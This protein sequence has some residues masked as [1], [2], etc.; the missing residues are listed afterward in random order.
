MTIK[1]MC[2]NA[3]LGA[4]TDSS[5]SPSKTYCEKASD[6]FSRNLTTRGNTPWKKAAHI[7]LKDN[8]IQMS[9]LLEQWRVLT[10]NGKYTQYLYVPIKQG[11]YEK[12]DSKGDLVGSGPLEELLQQT[13]NDMDGISPGVFA[14]EGFRLLVQKDLLTDKDLAFLTSEKSGKMFKTHNHPVLKM[15][16]GS[17]DDFVL[18]GKRRYYTSVN[19]RIGLYT[20]FLCREWYANSLVPLRTWF[21][22]KGVDVSEILARCRR[23]KISSGVGE[24][25]EN[26]L[27]IIYYGAPGT[28]KSF[29]IDEVIKQDV[30]TVRTTFHPDSDYS[31]FVGTYK[32]TMAKEGKISYAFV[33]QAFLK[34]YINAWERWPMKIA[35]FLVIE[36]INRGNCAQ[37]FGD[38]FQL[39]DRTESGWSKY[40][41]DGDK[42]LAKYLGG[43]MPTLSSADCPREYSPELWE[44]IKIGEKMALPPNLYIWAT[45]NTS[46][47]SLFPVDSAF[48]RRWDWEYVPI[49][50]YPEKNYQLEIDG[51]VYEWWSFVKAIND[52]IFS[53]TDS[54]DKKLGYFFVKAKNVG[55][56]N[57]IDADKFLNK[58]I[59]YLWNDVF[60]NS[61]PEKAFSFKWSDGEDA[62]LATL[63]DFFK[64]EDGSRDD[65]ML[66][67]F[68]KGLGVGP[69]ATEKRSGSSGSDPA[70]G[71][72]VVADV[73]PEPADDESDP[74]LRS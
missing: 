60:K 64:K 20:Y 39:L 33:G 67:A 58:V 43:E 26:R 44:K 70:Y 40:P 31:S 29:H 3:G 30:E 53:A 48:K 14:K 61:E 18:H 12:Y 50:N 69:I 51:E 38:V 74:A 4:V 1:E 7:I 71:E 35:Q 63:Q 41:I 15:D 13:S 9:F 52:K 32:P 22:A 36:E 6:A 66:K 57:V 37:I 34:A 54:E 10:G 28:G 49:K 45:M 11:G 25:K 59:F 17:P 62:K 27:Q 68:L 56:R 65:E 73:T 19:F 72:G 46:D 21:E 2:E 5:I 47:Q 42:D 55:G 23:G 16:I 8:D 24:L